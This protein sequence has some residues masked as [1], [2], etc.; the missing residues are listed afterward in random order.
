MAV[1]VGGGLGV[2]DDGRSAVAWGCYNDGKGSGVKGKDVWLCWRKWV[3]NEERKED[4]ERKQRKEEGD[5]QSE[6][7]K[8]K[9]NKWD[10]EWTK[11]NKERKKKREKSVGNENN[12]KM[13]NG[14]RWE[15]IETF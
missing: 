6:V 3:T 1:A 5:K 8:Q 12:G 15:H 7:K 10:T 11:E 4:E 13:F 14:E 2:H 9:R